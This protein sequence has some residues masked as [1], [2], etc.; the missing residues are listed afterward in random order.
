[1]TDSD[2]MPYGIHK[3]VKMIDVPASYLLWL[4]ENNKCSGEVKAYIIDNL[5]VIKEEIRRSK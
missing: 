2:K 5:E 3:D 4:Y 1:M